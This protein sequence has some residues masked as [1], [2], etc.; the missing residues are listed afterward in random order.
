MTSPGV[1]AMAHVR[2]GVARALPDPVR[3]GIRG[4]AYRARWGF[5]PPPLWSDWSE[6]ERL[7]RVI[8]RRGIA[9]LPGDVVEIGVLLG[10]G[11][12]KLCKY[13]ERVAPN[14]RVY[15]IDIFDP[16]F[17]VTVS[18]AGPAMSEVYLEA[19]DGRDQRAVF[20][21]ITGSCRNLE[22]IAEDS[23]KVTLPPGPIAFAYIDGNHAAAYVRSDFELV[24]PRLQPGGLVAFDDYGEDHP[25]VTQTVHALIGDHADEI[26]RVWAAG[27]RTFF[28]ERGK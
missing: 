14:K 23:A 18:T 5:P 9:D 16:A 10:G 25:A 6:Y 1:A 27:W 19:L 26:A 21:E 13:F 8:E 20:D 12:Y 22:V 17:D 24:W 2:R 28:I 3:E 4:A 7:L 15:A 11:T